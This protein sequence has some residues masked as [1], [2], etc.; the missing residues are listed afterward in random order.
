LAQ[1]AQGWLW[2]VLREKATFA[3]LNALKPDVSGML[4]GEGWV[5]AAAVAPVRAAVEGA[6]AR[7]ALG[8]ACVVGTLPHPWPTPPTAFKLNAFTAPYQVGPARFLFF[9]RS[10]FR[11]ANPP[12]LPHTHTRTSIFIVFRV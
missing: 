4:R 6:H 1:L 3:T 11:L 8:G 2:Q 9:S 5:A 10:K 12:S 7:M